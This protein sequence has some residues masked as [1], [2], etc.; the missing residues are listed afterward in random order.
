MRKQLTIH[1]AILVAMSSSVLADRFELLSGYDAGYYPGP[2]RN[3]APVPGPGYPGTFND[4][5]RLAGCWDAVPPVNYVGTG[6]PMF[7]PNE[8]GALS[9][10]FRRGSVPLGPPGNLPF[11]G[12]EFLAG[13]LLDLDGDLNNGSRSLT[14]VNNVQPVA[15]PNTTSHVEFDIDISNLT[16]TLS[17][18]DITGTNEG[19]PNVGPDIATIVVTLA[20]TTPEGDTGPA[21]NPTVDTRTGTLTSFA[22]N[23]GTL[24]GVYQITNLG[25][26]IWEDTIDPGS[27]TADIL[28]TLQYLGT[29]RGW[30][31]VRNA[32]G[33][34][35]T[36][37][38]EGLGT[39]LWPLVNTNAVGQSFNT[40]SGGSATISAG[41]PRDQFTAPG[42]GGLALA[43]FGGDIGA[44][45]DATAAA[46]SVQRGARSFVYLESAGWGINNSNDPVFGDTI[47]Y[48]IV[49]IAAE[50]GCGNNSA[51]DANCDGRVDNFDIDAFVLALTDPAGY[52][53]AYPGC[54]RVCAADVNRDDLVNNFDIDPFVACLAGV[55]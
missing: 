44:Y 46:L 38:G 18:V 50:A 34:F 49:L 29:F 53:A 19:G 22:G 54:D 42:N 30:Y 3:I 9:F 43:S 7:D 45:L 51:C 2:A 28:G 52:A 36:L 35:P 33:Q 37:T 24:S 15:I 39:T 13:P 40:A 14:P 26:E 1:A 25:Y 47:G 31:I 11:M 6:T 12:I 32:N 16:I 8:F 55:P 5:M 21:I 27:S 41:V 20:G 23:S 10:M 4:S 48:D 17:R